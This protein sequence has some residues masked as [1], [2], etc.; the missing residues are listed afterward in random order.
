MLAS[1]LIKK[2]F[3]KKGG[4]FNQSSCVIP[5][6]II[7]LIAAVL[8]QFI[9]WIHEPSPIP[10]LPETNGLVQLASTEDISTYSDANVIEPL[11]VFEADLHVIGVYT[12]ENPLMPNGTVVLVYARDGWRF[13]EIDYVP[14]MTLDEQRA[15]SNGYPITDVTLDDQTNGILV[16]IWDFPAC[17]ES[18]VEGFP[19]KC[20]ITKILY[21][22]LFSQMISIAIDGSHATEG[23]IIEIA[24]SILEHQ[25]MLLKP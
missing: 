7:V 21:F 10:L 2:S 25:N 24:R 1:R 12:E 20:E 22:P 3:E 9:N 11:E 8:I 17:L 13:V 19:G 18:E 15:L 4:E 5:L 16:S 6:V 23:E 14:S